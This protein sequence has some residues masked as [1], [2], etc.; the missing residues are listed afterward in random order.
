MPCPAWLRTRHASPEHDVSRAAASRMPIALETSRRG[1]PGIWSAPTT[2]VRLKK[3]IVRT[4]I[5]EAVADLDEEQAEIV[6]IL[7]WVGGAHPSTAC[8]AGGVGQRTSTPADIVEAVRTLALIARDDVIAGVLNRNGWTGH[9]NRFTRERVTALRSHYGSR[10]SARPRRE[11][12]LAEP[13]PGGRPPRVAARPAPSVGTRP[14][15]P[16]CIL[17]RTDRGCSAEPLS[18]ARPPEPSLGGRRAAQNTPRYQTPRSKTSSPQLHSEMCVLMS[19]CRTPADHIRA[20]TGGRGSN[21]FTRLP[22]I[23]A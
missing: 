19:S 8:H 22:Q 23:A 16:R 7:H 20:L 13:E 11:Q 15:S 21:Y 2:D 18:R 1:S 14:R 4:L 6:L 10:C 17:S 3:R 12:A 9:G 5:H